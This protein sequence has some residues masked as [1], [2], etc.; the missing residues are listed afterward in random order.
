[1]DALFELSIRPAPGT[2]R[3]VSNTLHR[4]LKSAILQG[5]IKAGAKLPPTRRAQ[6]VFGVSRNTAQDVYER[7]A[8]E[9]LATA[10]HGSGTYVADPLPTVQMANLAPFTQTPD[11][12]VNEFWLRPDTS[13]SLNFW[14]ETKQGPAS[15]ETLI[16]LRPSLIDPNFFPF[17]TFRQVMAREL[18][19][20]ETRPGS[21]R[22]HPW[23]QGNPQLRSATADHIA[24]TRAVACSA[25]DVLV[26][27]GA[28]QAWDLI[29]RVLVKPGK[30]VVAVEDPGYPP[31]RIPFAA[32]GAKIVPVRV[33]EEGLVISE[34][35]ADAEIICV[36]PSHQFPLGMSMSAGR[37]AELVDLARRNHAV[38]LEDDYDG[39][40]RYD[41]NPLDALR[42]AA[43]ADV[44]FYIGT[45]S[46]CM[47]PSLRLGF[48][49]PPPWAMKALITAK[50]SM[51]WYSSVPLQLAV[52]SFIK[53]GHLA[54]HIQQIRRIYVERRD[55]LIASLRDHFEGY[56]EPITPTYG[57]HLTACTVREIDTKLVSRKLFERGIRCHSLDRYF[58]G[59]IDRSGFVLG[60]ASANVDEL[61]T[62]VE[63]LRQ[64]VILGER[65]SDIATRVA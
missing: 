29:A 48:I 42:S 24:L 23:N 41:G 6:S 50:N 10:V 58:L 60:Y 25:D 63:A 12:R 1:M 37:R 57:M 8:Q 54:R 53:D 27:S 22:N 19:R 47:V 2:S 20:L 34:I 44:V 62:A 51:D 40:F 49:V 26:T 46:K 45:F 52:A 55:S 39:E 5:R 13:S 3:E 65:A 17:A 14:H 32:A 4:Q 28:Q 15:N 31:M 18:R 30:T 56:L 11:P 38:V 33:D 9:G 64:E 61:T 59:P 7:L 35:P 21:F 43:S 36:C 16:D